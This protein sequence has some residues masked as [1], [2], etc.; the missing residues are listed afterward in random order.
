MQYLRAA[1]PNRVIRPQSGLNLDSVA[2]I[3][4]VFAAPDWV[5]HWQTLASAGLTGHFCPE[6][7]AIIGS[8]QT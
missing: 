5:P 6:M 2:R 3:A 7:R 4:V 8:F 1:G